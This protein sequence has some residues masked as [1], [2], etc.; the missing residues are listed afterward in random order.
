MLRAPWYVRERRGLDLRDPR[1]LRPVV[2]MYD[3]TDFV[4]QMIEDPAD[5]LASGW[6]TAGATRVP[7]PRRPRTGIR[8][9]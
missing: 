3:R 6:T 1:A 2:Q 7:R 5:S 9:S 8:R 4:D